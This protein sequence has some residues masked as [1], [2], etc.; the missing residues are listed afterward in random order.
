MQYSYTLRNCGWRPSYVFNVQPDKGKGDGVSVRFMA[1]VWQFSGMDW[2]DTRLTLVSRGQ[3]PREPAPLPQ[4]VI[5]SQPP[6]PVV[7]PLAK[8][9]T[10]MMAA[11]A[12]MMEDAVAPAAQVEA[13]TSGMYAA[14]TPAEKGLPE[15]RSRLLVLAD[16]W[17]APLQWLARPSVGDSRVWLMAR[18]SL[19]EGQAWPD[20]LA[21]FSVDGQSVG[22]GRFHPEGN[23]VT[24]YFGADPRV[25]VAATA[26]MRQRGEKGFIGKSR[27][28]TWGW[29]YTVRNTRD[30]SVTVRLERPMPMLVDQG[31]TVTYRDKPQAQQDAKKHLLFWNVEAPAGGKGEVKHEL[32]IT[33][34]VDIELNP[35]AP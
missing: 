1:E 17:K 13:E 9:A 31:V 16:E 5:D 32:T 25:Q 30:R 14:W 11:P 22:A 29:T 28:W 24:L 27:T 23:E 7:Q 10:R 35:D 34:P 3:G 8:A 20:G 2:T 4:W 21:E 18:Y 12:P 26:D 6:P 15:G 33:S 19:P